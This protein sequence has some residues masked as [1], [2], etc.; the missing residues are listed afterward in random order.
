MASTYDTNSDDVN[1]KHPEYLA[2]QSKVTKVFN[3]FSGVDSAIQYLAQAPR[4]SDSAYEIRQENATLKNFVKRATEAFVGMIYRK[5]VQV[6]GFS[7]DITDIA[8]YIDKKSNMNKFSRELTTSLIRDGKVFLA[9]DTPIGGGTPYMS[10][11]DR[12][13]VINWR[14]NENNEYKM[15]VYTEMVEEDSGD[16]GL[17]EVQQWRVFRDDGT[18]ETWREDKQQGSYSLRDT[19]QTEFDYIPIVDIDLDDIP[20]LYDIAKLTIKHMNRTSFKDKYL[21]MAAIPV[22]VIWDSTGGDI[23]SEDGVV[24]AKPVY[25]IGVE[26]AFVFSGTKDEADF[27]WRELSGNSIKVLQDDLAVIEEDI[28]S[29]VIRAAQSDNT[30]IKTA[31]QSFYEAAESSNRV[32]V[33]ANAV[34]IG[35]NKAMLMLA[36]MMNE[37]VDDI[38]RVIVNKDF[39]A[40]MQGTDSLRLLWEIY[41]G[42]SLSVETFLK[43]L[44]SF[45]VIDIGSVEEE[46]KRIDKDKFVPASKVEQKDTTASMD[47]RTVSAMVK[48]DKE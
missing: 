18:V 38:A 37:T 15:L 24:G 3:V 27:Q 36:D 28:T 5:P 23:G 42:G 48:D 34:E 20:P 39:N 31:T 45:E 12:L 8:N 43:S 41:L 19:I 47:N 14:K 21:D 7:E 25:V 13:N 22:P 35:L 46:L 44:E 30:T 32:T 2:Y 6:V 11:L 26:E 9:V 33:I 4:E 40:I 17:V 16:F 29:G 1:F 10:I